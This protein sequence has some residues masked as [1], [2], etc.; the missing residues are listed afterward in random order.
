M[1]KNE[2]ICMLIAVYLDRVTFP[3]MALDD[4]L[5]VRSQLVEF[6]QNENEGFQ[7]FLVS[8]IVASSRADIP[9]RTTLCSDNVNKIFKV[10]YEKLLKQ[11]KLAPAYP[12]G[13]IKEKF[14]EMTKKYK[15]NYNCIIM[16]GI[17]CAVFSLEK[18]SIG[19]K[20]VS[21]F[22]CLSGS[23][24]GRRPTLSSV[25]SDLSGTVYDFDVVEEN[26]EKR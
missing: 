6:E 14:I 23:G 18:F 2:E 12:R 10:Y 24:S 22:K 9:I 16:V 21:Q 26:N 15:L 8:S 4:R 1:D 5:T 20:R 13:S 25:L 17:R 3:S 11:L 19:S 7:D